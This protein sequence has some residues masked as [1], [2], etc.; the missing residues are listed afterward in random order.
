MQWNC[1]WI[2][3]WSW[4]AALLCCVW[5][6]A[7][8]VLFCLGCFCIFLCQEKQFQRDHAV[9]AGNAPVSEHRHCFQPGHSNR[10]FQPSGAL[11][12][13]L[14]NSHPLLTSLRRK[15]KNSHS[16]NWSSST[17]SRTQGSSLLLP[18]V[19]RSGIYN[20]ELI[21]LWETSLGLCGSFPLVA[22][23]D[24]GS[25]SWLE[26]ILGRL[27]LLCLLAIPKIPQ[28]MRIWSC[29][30]LLYLLLLVVCPAFRRARALRSEMFSSIQ[31]RFRFRIQ[32]NPQNPRAEMFWSIQCRFKFKTQIILKIPGLK[33]FYP[34]SADS[35]LGSK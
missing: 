24:F 2:P 21:F 34:F 33:Y 3:F 26:S 6:S 4:S 5:C 15:L 28:V 11:L 22:S 32:I 20:P 31:C 16:N 1:C 35:S 27:T 25:H 29:L 12:L 30:L 8:G 23:W 17:S 10:K 18:G 19:I 14:S 7:C 13:Q 9:G